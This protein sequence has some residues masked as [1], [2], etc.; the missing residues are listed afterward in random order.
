MSHQLYALIEAVR[1][2]VVQGNKRDGDDRWS[3][4][5]NGFGSVDEYY[6]EVVA[7]EQV[8]GLPTK[9]CQTAANHDEC[10]DECE[11]SEYPMTLAEVCTAH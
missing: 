6:T 2:P 7:I 4:L 8:H 5:D 3:P 11:R 9:E 1:E 10:C